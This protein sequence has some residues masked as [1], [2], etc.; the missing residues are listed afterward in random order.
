M[1]RWPKRTR[2]IVRA[3]AVAGVALAAFS[4]PAGAQ[5]ES[6]VATDIRAVSAI[7]PLRTED[8]QRALDVY[9]TLIPEGLSMPRDPAV[10]VWL[11][12]LSAPRYMPGRPMDD[13]GHWIEGAI[14]VR[15]RHGSEEGWFPIHYP[16]TAEFWFEAGRYVGLP[17]RHAS[18]SITQSG[19]GWTAE[20][21]PR[22]TTK[23]SMS[24]A[25]QPAG[26][27]AGAMQRAYHVPTDPLYT[28][29]PALQGPDLMRVQYS[30]GPPAPFQT[31][32]PGGAPAWSSTAKPDR[33]TVHLRLRGDID[34]AQE[35]D[36]PKIF[37]KGTSLADVIDV[38]QTVPGTHAFFAVT[39]G[40]EST[41]IGKGRYGPRKL[42]SHSRTGCRKRRFVVV[43]VRGLRRSRV[44]SIRVRAGRRRVRARL[45]RHGRIRLDFRHFG[46]TNYRVRVVVV[47][48]SGKR[49]VY[50][51][52]V[53]RCAGRH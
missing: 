28:L 10:G 17:K 26:G 25:W 19:R 21:T 20:A 51:R 12:E 40:S 2:D 36:L 24:L 6:G 49:H 3:A 8:R 23:P 16:V 33:G 32:I 48:R 52:K 50:K 37:P 29:N 14:Q 4:P 22:D 30:L 27:D 35:S 45:R 53:R 11:A 5:T 46:R 18:A 7:A 31:A 47:T 1:T 44:R 15:A 9:S 41:S 43:R 42:P 13:A 34:A 38:D 39:L